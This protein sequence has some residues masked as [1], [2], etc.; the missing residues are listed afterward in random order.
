[1]KY[2][3]GLDIGTSSVKGV[4][5]TTDGEIR[6]K[7]HEVF[8]YICAENNV[9]EIPAERFISSCLSAIKK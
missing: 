2:L 1:M 8:E 7:A 6:A 4:L 5:M 9:V 3:I